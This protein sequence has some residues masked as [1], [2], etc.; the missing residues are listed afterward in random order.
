MFKKNKYSGKRNILSGKGF[1]IALA[2]CVVAAGVTV[3]TVFG[4]KDI[5]TENAQ[6]VPGTVSENTTKSAGAKVSGVKDNKNKA[7]TAA[8]TKPTT[9]PATTIAVTTAAPTTAANE[10]SENIPYKSFYA[11]PLSTSIIKDF[12]NG[13]LVY[14][15]TMN[16][17]RVHNGIDFA[18]EDN[19]QVKA[20]NSGVV[21]SITDDALWGKCIEINHG[22]GLVA[23]YCGFKTVSV[24]KGSKVK[25]NDTLGALGVVPVEK[26]EAT[27]LH[28][29]ITIDSKI[30]D[31]LAAMNKSDAADQ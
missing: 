13:E 2:L 1:Y 30:V 7:S 19:E 8:T 25:I 4:N 6:P 28:F 29:E 9:A 21:L 31:P 20:I 22:N 16:D 10:F 17:Y 5:K 26:G 18:G 15:E 3:F 24:N 23:K 14:S 12:S 27:H 11:L